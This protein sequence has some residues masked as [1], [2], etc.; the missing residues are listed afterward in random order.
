MDDQVSKLKTIK[1]KITL[2]KGQ[3]SLYKD[4]KI[5]HLGNDEHLVQ[6]SHK[7]KQF[8]VDKLKL[9]LTT[10]INKHTKQPN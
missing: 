5:I 4:Y 3:I 9:N 7:G 1:E 8:D 2:L 10:L 6:Y